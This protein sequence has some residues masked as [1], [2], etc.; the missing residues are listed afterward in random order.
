MNSLRELLFNAPWWMLIAVF[1][2]GAAVWWSGNNR[3]NKRL[4]FG[5]LIVLALAVVWA[6]VGY[7]IDTPVEKVTKGTRAFVTAV[8]NRDKAT[9]GKLLHPRATLH[10]WKRQDIIDGAVQYADQYGLK[11]AHV[12]Q[13]EVPETPKAGIA[14]VL[15]TVFSNHENAMIP[16]NTINTSWSID[17][18][19]TE[20]GQWLI[21]DIRATKVGNMSMEEIRQRYFSARSR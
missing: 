11:G 16:V 20:D 9:L 5:G 3:Q 6:A 19:E 4:Q 1:V 13:D 8:V 10:G 7:A 15:L 12:T 2:V 18:W 17:W 21:K 14:T